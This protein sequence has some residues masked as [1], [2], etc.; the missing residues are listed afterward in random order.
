VAE[1]KEA[2][3]KFALRS[4]IGAIL[5]AVAVACFAFWWYYRPFPW[6]GAVMAI[7]SGSFIYLILNT[8]HKGNLQRPLYIGMFVIFLGTIL[9]IVFINN[10]PD[11]FLNWAEK[12]TIAYYRAGE[13][14]RSTVFPCTLTISQ[15]FLGRAATFST[16]TGSW[17]TTFPPSLKAFWLVMIPFAGT[18][19]VFGRSLCGWICPFGGLPEAMVTG[20][21]A[22]WQLNFLNKKVEKDNQVQIEGLKDWV[23]DV[24]YGILLGS[25]LLAIFV[26]FP[27]V[28][29]LCPVL[30]LSSM[31]AFW[32]I[33][34]LM[35]VFAL[36]L[37]FMTKKR[38]WCQIC[39]LGAFLAMLDKISFFRV[40]INK[41]KCDRCMDCVYECRM[42]ALTPKTLDKNGKPDSDCIRCG[43][44][45]EVCPEKAADMYFMNTSLKVQQI[46]IPLAIVAVL[47]WYLWFVMILLG[48]FI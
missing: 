22:R 4:R 30:W 32:T 45:I 15:V 31:P 9:A 2:R 23:K 48:K 6:L 33:I 21:R 29:L 13:S 10:N 1:T 43:R 28:C 19:L 46:F 5:W 44:C 38:W 8:R 7:L 16:S 34:G 27:V 20:K 18:I 41:K 37:P 40:R 11:A 35:V 3:M 39:P 24:K 26:V 42:F 36:A 14:L 47:A 17:L 12:H 25:L